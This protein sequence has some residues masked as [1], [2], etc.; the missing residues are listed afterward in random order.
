MEVVSGQSPS[1]Q[2]CLPKPTYLRLFP[3]GAIHGR[4]GLLRDS[5]NQPIFFDFVDSSIDVYCPT[6]AER[7]GWGTIKL[8]YR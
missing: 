5:Q 3:P 7:V 1:G 8:L 2:S 6:P 4:R